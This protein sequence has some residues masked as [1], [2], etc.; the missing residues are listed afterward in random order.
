MIRIEDS[1]V[2]PS[3]SRYF[4]NIKTTINGLELPYTEFTGVVIGSC[5]G[6]DLI[7]AYYSN[8]DSNSD[9]DKWEVDFHQKDGF[10]L[11]FAKEIELSTDDRTSKLF[12]I[13]RMKDIPKI[14]KVKDNLLF[15]A[16]FKSGQF[17]EE[18]ILFHLENTGSELGDNGHRS[19]LLA[20]R[21]R[22]RRRQ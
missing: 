10:E 18:S 15:D 19:K 1:N 16:A 7:L 20:S 17:T 8:Y 12:L 11:G 9:I 13:L 21:D 2:T 4:V 14:V 5:N 6:C 22:R 3:L